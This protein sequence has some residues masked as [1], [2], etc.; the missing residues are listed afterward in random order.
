MQQYSS[1]YFARRHTLDTGGEVKM[2]KH[3]FSE[4]S[5]IADLRGLYHRAPLKHIYCP[6][7][8]HRPLACGQKV[9]TFFFLKVVVMLHIKLMGM[10]HSAPHTHIFCPY[11]H[12][13]PKWFDQKVKTFFFVF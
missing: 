3:F 12:P 13:K 11:S 1:K 8:E 9:K 2:S 10:E 7:T 5:Y 6:Y 4:R